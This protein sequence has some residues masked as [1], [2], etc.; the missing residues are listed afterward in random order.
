LAEE[1]KPKKAE[2]V[3]I[4]EG[5]LAALKRGAEGYED[6]SSGLGLA[7][8]VTLGEREEAAKKLAEAKKAKPEEE[9]P[10]LTSQDIQRLYEEQG[11][12]AAASNVP[13][14]ITESFAQSLPQMATPLGAGAIAGSTLVYMPSKKICI[15]F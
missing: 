3:G 7:K 12:W 15:L 2:D 6:I 8:N 14:Y 9:L 5:T 4:I 11:L 1:K 10:Q 13:K